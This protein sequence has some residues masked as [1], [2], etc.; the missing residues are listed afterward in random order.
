MRIVYLKLVNVAGIF[1]GQNKTEIEIDFSHSKN[2]IVCIT[3]SNGSGKTALESSLTP[4]AGVTSMDERS[5]LQYIVPGKNGYK[6]IHYE[7]NGD[8]YVIKHYYKPS[9]KDSHTVK[10]YFSKNGEELNDNGNVT[11]FLALVETY[12]GLTQDMMRLIRL[13]TNVSSIIS[14]TPARRKEYIGKL[15]EEINLYL[16][17]YKNINDEI[18][19]TKI[20]LSANNTNLYNCH[21]TDPDAEEERLKEMTNSIRSMEKERDQL[22]AK[23]SKIQTLMME[24]DINDLRRKQN[25]A[26]SS[27]MEFEKIENQIKKMSLE[28]TTVD[29][30]ITKRQELMDK[31]VDVQSKINSYRISIDTTMRNIERLEVVIKRNTSNSDI[32]SI[33]AMID[34]LRFSIQSVSQEVVN[35]VPLGSS[36][37][38]VQQL[39]MRLSS[40]NQISQ[41]IH[42]LGN[43]PCKVY[44]KLKRE[45]KSVDEFLSIQ[46]KNNLSR[47]DE[48]GLIALIEKMFDE[49]GIIYPNC[50]KEYEG[51]PYYRLAD[52]IGSIH[53][54]MG[55]ES[56][57]GE[58]LRNIQ[59]ISNNVD[60]LLNE[61]DRSASIHIPDRIR[62]DFKESRILDRLDHHLPFFDLS[63]LQEYL[64]ILKEYELY[65]QN[66]DKLKQYETQLALYKSSGIDSQLKEIEQLKE[67]VKFYSTNIETLNS[68]ISQITSELN[69]ID[70][71]ISIV[72]KYKDSQK[73]RKIVNE[74]LS[75]TKKILEPLESAASEKRELEYEE[76]SVGEHIT[77]MR[78]LHKELE[79]RIDEYQKLLKE[80]NELNN[81]L[82]DLN[83]V[84]EAVSTKKGIPVIYMKRYL[85]K[86]K[87]VAN[88]LL[89]LI[90]NDRIRLGKF[91]LTQETFEIPFI[92]NGTKV[93]D[94]KYASQSEVPMMTMALSFAL[95]S[96]AAG[97][98]NILLLDEIDAGLDE[99]NRSAFLKMLDHQIDLLHAEQVFI[100]SHNLSQMINVPMDCICMSDTGSVSKLQNIIYE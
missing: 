32:Q 49:D 5:S 29:Q 28:D 44:I 60:N 23:I 35:F 1:V 57:D 17:I 33:I 10:S 64:S 96:Q 75:S 11:S 26:E 61:L 81:T 93:P 2:R 98:Y 51:C 4:F 82:K 99:A 50:D 62:D 70:N 84:L 77:Q 72:S 85:G 56:Y 94:V 95:A 27:L 87:K 74:T 69:D 42:T 55:G 67:S 40:F 6:E 89:A 46:K 14:L 13:G 25:E 76:R 16:K 59:V 83:M 38:E 20:L 47:I 7:H 9:G 88:D 80:S 92:N 45:K 86:I 41:M 8:L 30:L 65:T 12:F 53:E 68:S 52:T 91:N 43:T 3:G 54:R 97:I 37:D 48:N 63:G 100:I 79:N 36:S 24:N 71:K 19:V 78:E 18:R 73:Y 31:K 34:D 22:V 39:L 21:I 58:T 15:I 66:I 90:Y